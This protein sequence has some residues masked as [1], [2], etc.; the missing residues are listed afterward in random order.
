MI[1]PGARSMTVGRGR[2][3][4]EMVFSYQRV[5]GSGKSY[6]LRRVA[7]AAWGGGDSR[8]LRSRLLRI[9]GV[10]AGACEVRSSVSEKKRAFAGA[11]LRPVMGRTRLRRADGAGFSSFRPVKRPMGARLLRIFARSQGLFFQRRPRSRRSSARSAIAVFEQQ[12]GS[13]GGVGSQR[14]D[15]GRAWG[16]KHLLS[17]LRLA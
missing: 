6:E 3:W 1:S 8:D 7:R 16:G 9:K 13:S 10:S 12:S 4:L 11:K 5:A 2:Q 15:L 14:E 17:K